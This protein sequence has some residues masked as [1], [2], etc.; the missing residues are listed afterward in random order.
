MRFRFTAAGWPLAVALAA[1]SA[2]TG[3]VPAMAQT[4]APQPSSTV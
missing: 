1:G 2:V 4:V 3:S